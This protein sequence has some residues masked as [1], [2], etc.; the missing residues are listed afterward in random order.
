MAVF[1][2]KWQTMKI[3]APQSPLFREGTHLSTDAWD[4]KQDK[5][6]FAAAATCH[7]REINLKDISMYDGIL[8]WDGGNVKVS[9]PLEKWKKNERIIYYKTYSVK[10]KKISIMEAG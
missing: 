10:D 3:W 4:A 6:N 5:I 7:I 1:H 9:P 8:M 2:R